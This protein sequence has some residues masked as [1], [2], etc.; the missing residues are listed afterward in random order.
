MDYVCIL[1][2]RKL[3]KRQTNSTYINKYKN[4]HRY[5]L[6]T[7]HSRSGKVQKLSETIYVILDIR[8]I[9]NLQSYNIFFIIKKACRKYTALATER[10]PKV[11]PTPQM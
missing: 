6:L 11:D 9:K 1:L 7:D 4:R 8:N 3:P 10:L 5:I 2:I